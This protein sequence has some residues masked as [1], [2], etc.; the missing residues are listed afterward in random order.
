LDCEAF[1]RMVGRQ[2]AELWRNGIWLPDGVL[3]DERCCFGDASAAVKCVRISNFIVH[4]IRRALDDFDAA[5]PPVES[6]WVRWQAARREAARSRG[7]SESVAARLHWVAMFVDDQ[8]GGS[9]D[10]VVVTAAG[11]PVQTGSGDALRRAAAHF[12]I[13]RSVIERYGWRSAPRKEQPPATVVEV[14][15][16]EVDVVRGRWRLADA[17]RARYARA[18]DDASNRR[19]I[20]ADEF[21]S[22]MGKLSFAAQCYPLGRQS[23]HACWRAARV[24]SRM[25]RGLVRI[26]SRVRD[27]LLWWREHLQ[28]EDPP[29]IPLAARSP[30]AAPGGDT[31]VIYA[32]ASG[33]GGFAAWTAVA[34]V[35]YAVADR[36]SASE[37]SMLICELELL[38]S[39]IG[40]V[41]LAEYLP[42]DIYSFTDN[43]V[44]QSAMQRL[45]SE[46]EPMQR[47]L[48]AR[49]SWMHER[50]VAEEVRRISSAANLWADIGSRPEKGGLAEVERQARALGYDFVRVGVPGGWRGVWC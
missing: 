49:T 47:M 18:V 36:W 8:M 30:M 34:G 28:A 41:A 17:K 22:L 39:T 23:L 26:A 31:G 45:R 14:L 2:R 43:T 35:V 7:E 12:A 46:T 16:A 6:E 24:R 37:R 32:D 19:F 27:E 25:A 13:A 40:L 1:Y 9:A 48:A 5:H 50:G 42:R 29:G 4:Q 21:L 38:A 11:V 15:G 10:D 44:A 33:S 3:L 20:P